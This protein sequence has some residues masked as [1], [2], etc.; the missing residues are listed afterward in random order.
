MFC[1]LSNKKARAK[2]A[3]AQETWKEALTKM[4]PHRDWLRDET[5]KLFPVMEALSIE[6]AKA[7]QELR[8]S[9]PKNVT[10]SG[11]VIAQKRSTE[12]TKQRVYDVQYKLD[13]AQTKTTRLATKKAS[14]SDPVRS[15]H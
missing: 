2:L 13:G 11:L 1:S 12:E 6:V 14:T 9:W 5:E 10:L 4:M 3:A 7:R 8:S 15:Y